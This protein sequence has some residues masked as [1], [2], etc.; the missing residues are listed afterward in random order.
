MHHEIIIILS[1]VI[2]ATAVAN[3]HKVQIKKK[4]LL[5]FAALNE[6]FPI[7]SDI[8]CGVERKVVQ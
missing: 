6:K 3:D 2:Q 7:H 1:Y 8:C 4:N 5:M